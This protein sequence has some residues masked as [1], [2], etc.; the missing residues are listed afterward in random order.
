VVQEDSSGRRKTSPVVDEN[1]NEYDV[2]QERCVEIDF[3]GKYQ[4]MT[5]FLRRQT[6]SGPIA[7]MGSLVQDA[8]DASGLMFRRNRY[9]D[10]A[11]GRFTQEDPIGLAGG[12]N[13]Y[14][15]AEGDPVNYDD[16][17]GLSA[18]CDPPRPNCDA[19]AAAQ[20]VATS[21]GV[22]GVRAG[23]VRRG[24]EAAV[25]SIDPNDSQARSALKAATRRQ[26]PPMV[27]GYIEMTRLALVRDP[28]R[29]AGQISRM[30][31]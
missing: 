6:A 4:G 14:G 20:G 22:Q 19:A 8:Q 13:G 7:W 24:Y 23:S 15:F 31:A 16:P 11:S 21:A 26:T 5:R 27:R 1:G 12:L 28:G 9:Y 30:Q 17:Y 25:S 10:P 29:W 2:M 18:S 3:P